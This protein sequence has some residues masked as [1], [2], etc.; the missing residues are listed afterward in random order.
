VVVVLLT[1]PGVMAVH[2][3]P[4]GEVAILPLS[5]T[6][7]NLLLPK[8]IALIL[9]VPNVLVPTAVQLTVVVPPV[10]P[11]LPVLPDVPSSLPGLPPQDTAASAKVRINAVIVMNLPS[12]IRGGGGH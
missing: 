7:T 10:L 11:V 3:T 6:A 5:P 12:R 4:S 8:A 2:V 1:V 9:V